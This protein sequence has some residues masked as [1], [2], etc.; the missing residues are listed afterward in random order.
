[1]LMSKAIL[2]YLQCYEEDI[3]ICEGYL[4]MY[5]YIQKHIL[6]LWV[7]IC[8]KSVHVV[9]RRWL[10]IE[11]LPIR[12]RYFF[13]ILQYSEANDSEFQENMVD[14]IFNRFYSFLYYTLLCHPYL[15]CEILE[16]LFKISINF[17]K[18]D[19]MD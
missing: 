13:N 17:F 12:R 5:L 1:M 11:P 3:V 10:T 6:T 7:R 15:M 8:Y 14:I 2:C 16:I 4:R 18:N 9:S 19:S